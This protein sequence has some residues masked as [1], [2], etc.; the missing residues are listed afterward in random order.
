[1]RFQS[2]LSEAFGWFTKT[3]I[4][5]AILQLHLSFLVLQ[6]FLLWPKITF[7]SWP[8]LRV[9]SSSFFPHACYDHIYVLI[10]DDYLIDIM[11][12][13][14]NADDSMVILNCVENCVTAVLRSSVHLKHQLTFTHLQW[15]FCT[16]DKQWA[17]CF[18]ATRLWVLMNSQ[19]NCC[20][21]T[22]GRFFS[23]RCGTKCQSQCFGFT[24]VSHQTVSVRNMFNGPW[25]TGQTVTLEW[26]LWHSCLLVV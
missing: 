16:S 1:M 5:G 11:W 23:Y 8:Y 17:V 4:Y 9:P 10:R 14:H 24:A 18:L 13:P 19:V 12:L 15:A 6:C 20:K 3:G 22:G 7:N 21:L 2:F 25:N 26:V